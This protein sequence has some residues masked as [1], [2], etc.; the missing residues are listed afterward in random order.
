MIQRESHHPLD[1]V[2]IPVASSIV[3]NGSSD[4]RYSATKAWLDDC[5]QNHSHCQ[6]LT[7]GTQNLSL[8]IRLIQVRLSEDPVLILMQLVVSEPR[9]RY[10]TR[11]HRWCNAANMT[12]LLKQN[13]LEL[14]KGTP[15]AE[16]PKKYRDSMEMCR[17]LGIR[18]LWI[19]S[20]CLI[21][22]DA[23][24]CEKEIANM[25]NIYKIAYLNLAATDAA[26]F[27]DRGLY[28]ESDCDGKLPFHVPVH[29]QGLTMD[30][31]AYPDKAVSVPG[32]SVLMSRGWVLQERMLS[33]RTVFFDDVLGWECHTVLANEIF[34]R[35]TARFQPYLGPGVSQKL[36]RFLDLQDLSELGAECKKT[37]LYR[38]WRQV[39][40]EFSGC[41]L[42]YC[43]DA[44]AAIS[45]LARDFRR[46]LND[47]YLAG[48]W[49]N[50]LILSL[51]WYVGLRFRP[52]KHNHEKPRPTVYIGE[53]LSH[54]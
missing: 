40:V 5:T 8:P 18:Y 16:L 44:L 21:Q 26:N 25:G 23:A 43:A 22:D 10:A 6:R 45:G 48:I 15:I 31:L 17:R 33:S 28:Y 27:P 53:S 37:K 54:Q 41:E 2:N 14:Q 20:L 50:D 19:D 32:S 36:P 42:T 7:T 47:A 38:R 52:S 11:S 13:L 29:R 3:S 34:P 30:Y 24:D 49:Q 39:C 35:S 12:L 46:V 9:L 51:L 4:L 1:P